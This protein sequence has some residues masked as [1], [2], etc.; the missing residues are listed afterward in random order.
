MVDQLPYSTWAVSVDPDYYGERRLNLY[1]V[2]YRGKDK[3][4]L[5]AV[6]LVADMHE[7][8]V[9][10]HLEKW[11]CGL[12]GYSH[13]LDE[14]AFESYVE[15]DYCS[16][17]GATPDLYTVTVTNITPDG[18]VSKYRGIIFKTYVW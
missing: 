2:T 5:R 11:Y 6:F 16:T 17:I 15:S 14:I 13:D 9:K 3:T 1:E 12:S 18:I 4:T 10:W 7:K 8:E